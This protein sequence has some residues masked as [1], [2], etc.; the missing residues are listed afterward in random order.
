VGEGYWERYESIVDQRIRE[1][2]ERGAFDDLPGAG[3]P[4]KGLHGP[5]DPNWWLRSY[6]QREGLPTDALLPTP[7]RLRKEVER[8]PETVRDLATEDEV[9]AAVR[10]LNRRVAAYVRNPTGPR[11]S[12]RPAS[13]EDTLASWRERSRAAP[14][15]AQAQEPV[16]VADRERRRRR[17]WSRRRGS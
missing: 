8:L 10:D 9:R 4:L 12:V 7:L 5:D 6:L 2:Q 16:P 15:P 13:L 14:R 1:A 17:L 3:R 11:V